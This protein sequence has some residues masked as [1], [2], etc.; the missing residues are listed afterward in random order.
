ME[1]PEKQKFDIDQFEGVKELKEKIGNLYKTPDD[2]RLELIVS[3][4]A[5]YREWLEKEYGIDVCNQYAMYHAL[6]GSSI[7]FPVEKIDFPGNLI[8][9]FVNGLVAEEKF[10]DLR[11]RFDNL[12]KEH[13]Q[14]IMEDLATFT[15]ILREDSLKNGLELNEYALHYLLERE[16]PEKPWSEFSPDK[17]DFPGNQIEKFIEELEEKYKKE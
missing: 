9:K 17:I 1:N 3:K 8:E 14:K 4:I 12:Y 5:N 13:G 2:D 11:E 15:G 7:D 10:L 6:S 16:V